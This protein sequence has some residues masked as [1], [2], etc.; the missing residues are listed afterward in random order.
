MLFRSLLAAA[1]AAVSLCGQALAQE[2]PRDLLEVWPY[3]NSL[4]AAERLEVLEREATREGRLVIYAAMGTDRARVFLDLFEERYPGIAVEFNRM[5]TSELPQ[6]LMLEVRTGRSSVDLVMTSSEWLGVLSDGLAPYVPT[7]WDDL[8]PAF[9][10]GGV[11]EGWAAA[12]HDS[13]IEAIAWRTDRVD[14]AEAPASLDELSDPKWRGRVGTTRAREQFLDGYINLYGEEEA[15][16]KIDRL[17]E[18]NN[19]IF[20]SIAGLAEAL[21][22][23]EV[24]LAWGV[25]AARVERLKGVGAPVDYVLQQPAMTLNETVAVARLANNPYAAALLMEFLLDHETM[26]ASDV[27]EPG[28]LFGNLK[29]SF[30]IPQWILTA[31]DL[32]VYRAIPEDEF[33]TLNRIVEQKFVRR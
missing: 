23:G 17:A 7:V 22:A 32:T 14:A 10:H 31:E 2:A 33:R 21:G 20:P 3:L 24:D 19:R 15:M 6:K 1:A 25:S 30:T 16:E 5:S 29:G 28:R 9:R 13:L 27:I 11:E 26:E 12:D 4:P 8:H 18:L